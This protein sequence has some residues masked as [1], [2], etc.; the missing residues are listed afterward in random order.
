MGEDEVCFI[1]QEDDNLLSSPKLTLSIF[2]THS[3]DD[4]LISSPFLDKVYAQEG[5]LNESSR[6]PEWENYE[7]LSVLGEGAYGKVYRV[8]MKE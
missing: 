5:N 1:S 3:D 2:K 7:Y 4:E 8:K 6:I